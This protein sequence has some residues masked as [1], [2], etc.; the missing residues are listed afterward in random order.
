MV[1]TL[2][3]CAGYEAKLNRVVSFWRYWQVHGSESRFS[4][5]ETGSAT[6]VINLD[7][8]IWISF[9][10]NVLRKR[11]HLSLPPKLWA[12]SWVHCFFFLIFQNC[13]GNQR[14]RRKNSN[15]TTWRW[16]CV[17]SSQR[18][19]F[20]DKYIPPC[21]FWPG[22]VVPGRDQSMIDINLF[23]NERC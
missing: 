18:R 15:Q 12:W 17:T 21:P 13:E 3:V 1:S 14:W 2:S 9:R 19:R 4:S 16:S 6:H 10:G 11:M 20:L 7:E 5:H 8:T 22:V 23:E